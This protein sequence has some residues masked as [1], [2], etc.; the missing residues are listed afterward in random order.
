ML[1][2]SISRAESEGKSCEVAEMRS[3]AQS[4]EDE[5]RCIRGELDRLNEKM[6]YLGGCRDDFIKYLEDIDST[7]KSLTSK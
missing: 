1:T 4:L 2:A 7:Y 3:K 6:V 5:A